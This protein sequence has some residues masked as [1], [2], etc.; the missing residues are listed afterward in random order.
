MKKD[1]YEI[2]TLNEVVR[3]IHLLGEYEDVCHVK[4]DYNYNGNEYI[5]YKVDNSFILESSNGK[6]FIINVNADKE[7]VEKSDRT[8]IYL[9]HTVDVGYMLKPNSSLRLTSQIGLDEGIKSFTNVYRHNLFD[10]YTLAYYD[11]ND[12]LSGKVST[13]FDDVQ[14]KDSYNKYHFN[15][16][17]I[18]TTN[19]VISRDGNEL[20]KY[21]DKPVPSMDVVNS[22]D[23]DML[24][25]KAELVGIEGLFSPI[26]DST[27][28]AIKNNIEV[29]KV[30]FD[31]IKD[32]YNNEVKE[33]KRAIE[34]RDKVLEGTERM[35]TCDEMKQF[36]NAMSE[37][38]KQKR[39]TYNSEDRI[40]NPVKKKS[41]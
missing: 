35:F 33:I 12:E 6:K 18:E 15:E 29:Q 16:D 19:K 11:E 40:I 26:D 36:V 2:L 3:M 32:F 25:K 20:V 34:V 37:E 41:L 28:K 24:R 1:T 17:S 13:T 9:S 8:E 30:Y 7:V 22:F 31:G 10:D 5:A 14:L 38:L 39:E 21:F 27:V 23:A 4:L